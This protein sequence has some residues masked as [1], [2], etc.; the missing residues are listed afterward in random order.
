MKWLVQLMLASLFLMPRA[1]G[2]AGIY[3]NGTGSEDSISISVHITD[4]LGNPSGTSADSFYLSVIGP[5]GDSIATIAGVPTTPGLNIDSL[6]TRM[7]GWKYI[8]SEAISEIDGSGRPG[9]Y[10]LTFCAKDD[11]PGFI[12]CTRT[13]FQIV[14]THLSSQLESVTTILDSLLAALDTIQNLHNWVSTFDCETDTVYSDAVKISGDRSASDNFETMLDGSGG[15]RLSLAGFDINAQGNDT[16]VIIEA[17]ATGTG[18]GMFVRGGG[19]GGEGIKVIG[20]NT[21]SALVARGGATLGATHGLDLSGEG[22]GFGLNG[23]VSTQWRQA[24]ADAVWEEDTSSHATD[25]SFAMLIKDTAAYQ[26]SASGLNAAEVTDSVWGHLADAAWAVGTFGDYLDVPVSSIESSSGS[27]SYPVTMTSFDS[28][29]DLVVPGVRIAAYNTNLDA[30]IAIG[31]T[32]IDGTIAFNLDP[33]A[34]LISAFAPGYNFIA[35]DTLVVSGPGVDTVF[36]TA[37]DPGTP[38]SPDLCRVYGYLYGIDGLPIEGVAVTA[39]L[40]EGVVRHGSLIISPY[41]KTVIS[42]QD[43][44][45]QIDLIPS[46]ALNPTGTAYLISAVYPSGTILKKH[47]T[48]PDQSSWSISW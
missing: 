40:T 34:Y 4:S 7:V 46:E 26:G 20:G 17:S 30:L 8:Y 41:K 33:G 36:G 29:H 15:S 18:L 42:D 32:N 2:A 19:N 35:N 21:K 13:S 1:L 11:A 10:E 38:A 5:S 25:Q 28:I 43:G 37:F 22:E 9:T 14:S 3:T 16:A 27:G 23:T 45:F 47:L 31:L 39:Q 12:N 6:N 48:V 44:Y 24:I